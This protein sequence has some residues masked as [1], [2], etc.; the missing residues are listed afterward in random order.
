MPKQR[1]QWHHFYVLTNPL[2]NFSSARKYLLC[3]ETS[4]WKFL[5]NQFYLTRVHCSWHGNV[6]TFQTRSE[7]GDSKGIIKNRIDTNRGARQE[8]TNAATYITDNMQHT[9][10]NIR[11][12][13]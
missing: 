4:N 1:E 9:T 12:M 13:S 6:I 5:I 11:L 2:T 3:T 10:Y 8:M 7:R